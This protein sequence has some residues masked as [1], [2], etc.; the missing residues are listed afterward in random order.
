MYHIYPH[1]QEKNPNKNK[2]KQNHYKSYINEH[3]TIHSL[4]TLF[5]GVQK[6]HT[7]KETH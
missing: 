5:T 6:E 4:T 1:P 3:L 7:K 2:T